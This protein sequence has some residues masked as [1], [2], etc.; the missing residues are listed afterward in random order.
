MK[1]I[2]LATALLLA[3]GAQAQTFP[4][5]YCEIAD[6]AQV[7]VEEISTVS[8]ADASIVNTDLSSVLINA[9]SFAA[10]V[11]PDETYALVV[12]GNT[13]GDFETDIVAFIDWNHNDILDDEGEVYAVGTL[14]DT[15]GTDGVSVSLDITIPT[16]AV[17][18][19]TRIRITKTYTDPDPDG[20]PASL[21]EVDACGVVFNVFGESV[22]PGYG[23]ALDFTLNLATLSTDTFERNAL[24]VYPNPAK[25]VLNIN[26][27]SNLT[28]VT[29][30]NIVGQEVLRRNVEASQLQIDLSEF[31][32][33]VYIV[34]LFS[35]EGQHSFRVVKQ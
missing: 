17:L 26:Y 9:T 4:A 25:D 13:E 2:T 28:G 33:G 8:F 10:N 30:Y 3:I 21:A 34:K 29:V 1:K 5:P 24:A 14:F 16:D 31:T 7:I 22:E 27:K 20:Y 12:T 35:E 15:D 32:S 6:E 19:E 18:G 11:A 23:Q